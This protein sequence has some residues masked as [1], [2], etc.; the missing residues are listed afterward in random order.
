ME[1]GDIDWLAALVRSGA[2]TIDEIVCI[3]GIDT[4]SLKGGYVAKAVDRIDIT[5]ARR[6]GG[7]STA[8]F[9]RKVCLAA[10][11]QVLKA[12]ATVSGAIAVPEVIMS[13]P[14]VE[15][16][17]A[18]RENGF[19]SP[20]YPGGPLTFDDLIPHTV[21]VTLARVHAACCQTSKFDW[22]WT[23]DATHIDRL[24]ANALAKLS[25]S[26]HFKAT[27][28]D[29]VEWLRRLERIG[30]SDSL[31]TVSDALPRSLVHGDMHPGNIVL[32]SDG[33]PVIID[34]GNVCVGPPMLDVANIIR[35]DSTE[36]DIYLDAYRAAGGK[37]DAER[38]RRA[39]CWARAAT[40]LRYLP[41]IAEH[42]PDASRMI[43]QIEEAAEGLERSELI[44]S[45]PSGPGNH[46]EPSTSYLSGCSQ[47]D[48]NS[49][50]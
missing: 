25:A 12:L 23:F 8:S 28:A 49:P 43:M 45:V 35:I 24:H 48:L 39:Y 37:I 27:T 42:K 50:E 31:R 4:V 30:R 36:W 15:H 33:L 11:V 44:Q 10:E 40:G 32:R 34:W 47:S 3:E 14:S 20:F 2:A 38:C 22:T 18:Q 13:W 46:R 16:P 9:V 19:I 29:H 21:L 1:P 6:V 26:D 41:W 5:W 17:A 7:Q